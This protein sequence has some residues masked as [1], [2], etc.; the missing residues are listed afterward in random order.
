MLDEVEY[1]IRVDS[2][3]PS[4]CSAYHGI[5]HREYNLHNVCNKQTR[6]NFDGR[7]RNAL[8]FDYHQFLPH[9]KQ[10]VMG[11]DCCTANNGQ[12]QPF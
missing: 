4:G 9:E 8:H 6:R 5:P 1:E 10:Q 2:R 11:L 7:A 12:K 3:L